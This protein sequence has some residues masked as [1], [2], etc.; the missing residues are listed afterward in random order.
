MPHQSHSSWICQPNN[1]GWAVQ[2]MKQYRLL[3]STD[4]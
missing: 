3:S 4:H 2:I 1:I